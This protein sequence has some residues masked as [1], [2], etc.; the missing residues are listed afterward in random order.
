MP[1]G[2]GMGYGWRRDM[3][4][5]RA[6]DPRRAARRCVQWSLPVLPIMIFGAVC[7][8]VGVFLAQQPPRLFRYTID[9]IIVGERFHEVGRIVLV[10]VGILVAGQAVNALS[11]FWMTVAGQRLLHYMRI[12]LYDHMQSLPLTFFDNHRVGDLMA[13]VTGD[14]RQVESLILHTGNSL[15]RQIFGMGFALYYMMRYSPLLTALILIPVPVLAIGVFYFS[16]RM[17]VRYRA[18]RESMGALGAKLQENLS[19]IRVI[20]AFHREPEEH[21]RVVAVSRDVMHRSIHATR[22]AVIVYPVMHFMAASGAVIV[23]GA[24]AVLISRDA[25]TIGALTAFSMYVAHFYQPINEFV[26]TFDTIQRALASGER[27]FEVL[28]TESDIRDPEE[29]L[30]MPPPRGAVTFDHVSFGYSQSDMVLRDICVDIHPGQ[31]I[32][33]VGR[34]GAGKTSFVNLIPRFYDV[35]EGSVRVDGVDVRRVRLA[36][37]RR[38][39]A[40]VLQETFLFD[41]TIRENL[42]YGNLEADDGMIETAARVANAH[43]FIEQLPRGYDTPV[44]ERGVKLSGGQKQ[45]MSIARAVLANPRILILDEATSSV[46]G[47]SE[48]LIHQALQRL[49]KGRT[50]LI[51]AH[52]LS[53]VRDADRILVL[54]EGRITEEGRHAR[55]LANAGWYADMARRQIAMEIG[56]D[57]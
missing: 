31:R 28:D 20:Q 9:E 1:R 11:R 35:S 53:T 51:I 15:V 34:S 36:D 16:R 14:V 25:L 48:Q 42:R 55:L 24:G 37:L 17:R 26:H 10:Y 39:M 45:R 21:E 19:G 41:G 44:G 50:T 30:P 18:I 47:E 4:P 27:I 5:R 29:P 13:R 49:M 57:P 54:E 52:R 32:A 6:T 3:R 43:D 22:L 56:E 46:D 7:T 33:L 12:Q 40:M 8:L 38:S 23:L 2:D